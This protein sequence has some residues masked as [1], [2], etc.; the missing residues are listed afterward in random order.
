MTDADFESDPFDRY[1]AS[2]G[3]KFKS[4]HEQYQL[5]Y[6]VDRP[7]LDS[8]RSAIKRIGKTPDLSAFTGVR[9]QLPYTL[10]VLE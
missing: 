8:A 3:D 6:V 7:Y 4:E 9:Q 1:A 5:S 2:E 10:V